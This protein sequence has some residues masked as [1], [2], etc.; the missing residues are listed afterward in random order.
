[1]HNFIKFAAPLSA[2][3]LISCAHFI[4]AK[5]ASAEPQRFTKGYIGASVGLNKGGTAPGITGRI[6]F[7]DVPVSLRLNAFFG[8]NK[9]VNY[10][11]AIPTLTYDIGLGK[12]ANLYV[13]GGYMGV[14][15]TDGKNSV[16]ANRG[17][18]LIAGAEGEISKNVVLYGDG[19][20]TNDLAIWKVGVGYN[21]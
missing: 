8:S 16:V 1:M 3:L 9:N 15:A 21:F 11:I 18:A 19:T 2:A 5:P 17:A 6:S 10:T 7:G 14:G 4:S 13:G 20:L 12:R